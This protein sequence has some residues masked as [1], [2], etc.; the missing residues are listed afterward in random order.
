MRDKKILTK[1]RLSRIQNCLNDSDV[2]FRGMIIKIL[3]LVDSD[4]IDYRTLFS[5]NISELERNVNTESAIAYINNQT[6]DKKRC[7]ELFDEKTILRLTNLLRRS[8]F[9]NQTKVYYCEIIN[10]CLEYSFTKGLDREGLK[11]CN[12]IIDNTL[13]SNELKT[14]ALRSI[15]L[16]AEKS[17][18][19]PGKV[20][21]ALVKNLDSFDDKSANFVVMT[22]GTI[23]EKS[24]IKNVNEVSNKLLDDR[25]IVGEGSDITFEQRS[26]DNLACSSISSIASKVFVNSLQKGAKITKKSLE[27]LASALDSND[28]QTRILSAK[29]LSIAASNSIIDN[30]ILVKLREYVEDRIP[31]VATYTTAAYTEGLAKLARGTSPIAASHIEFLPVIYAV[32]DLILNAE[33]FTEQVNKNILSVLLNEAGKQ[34]FDEEVFRIF[35]HIL[36]SDESNIEEAINILERYTTN[37]YKIPENTIAALENAL[38]IPG[39]S[40]QALNVLENIIRNGQV[41]SDKTLQIFTDNLYLSEDKTLRLKSFELLD[42]A[43]HNQDLSDEIFDK[44]ELERAGHVIAERLADKEGAVFYLNK[45]T[46]EGQKLP[47]N[48]FEALTDEIDHNQVLSILS[49]VSKNKQIMPDYLIDKLAVNLTLNKNRVN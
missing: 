26:K 47:I 16:S 18:I 23:C 14:E 13:A 41:V 20:V 37:K 35:D 25:V 32:E 19:L 11:N 12:Y 8:S 34:E 27:H 1:E 15:L 31:D 49:N 43:G 33:N 48:T 44:V 2:K 42:I 46:N 39:V 40:A 5:T 29:S 21:Q 10:N 4:N 17:K 38:G 6:K 45:Q 28:K 3:C 30:P 22:L 24:E 9:D 36:F 7:K